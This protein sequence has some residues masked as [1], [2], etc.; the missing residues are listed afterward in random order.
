[1]TKHG[2]IPAFTLSEMIVVIAIT[3]VVVAMAY[4]VLGLVQRQMKGME[5]NLTEETKLEL[6]E[7]A[8]WLDFNRYQMISFD[9]STDEI[10]FKT[11]L[12]SVYYQLREDKVIKYPDTFNIRF[13]VKT[14]Y[15]DGKEVTGG[16]IDAIQLETSLDTVGNRK[17]FIFKEND[18]A[19]Y[20][21]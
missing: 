14:F 12:D 5:R 9:P 6:L 8:L 21:N 13:P 3:A 10:R 20:M 16:I 11:A 7:Q 1:M 19:R 17:L 4:A 15:L 18:A 2:K